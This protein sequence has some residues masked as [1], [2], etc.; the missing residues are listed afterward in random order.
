MR[1]FFKAGSKAATVFAIAS[2]FAVSALGQTALRKALDF[3]NDGKADY[4]IFRPSN[5]VW[6]IKTLAADTA[7][8]FGLANVDYPSPGD[9]DGDGKGDLSVWRDTTGIWYRLNSSNGTFVAN[10]FGLTGDEPVARDY[11][12]DGK[13]D[14]GIVRRSNG[15][16]IWYVLRSLDGGFSAT[17]F[18][19]STDY[20]APGDYD[21]DAKFDIGVQRPGATAASN[22]T[23]Y[24]QRSSDQGYT[25]SSWG[26]SNDLVVPGDYDGDGKTDLAVI[27]EGASPTANLAWYILRSSDGQAII[28]N[29]GLTG[30]DLSVQNDYD[31]DGKA[32]IAI[33]RDNPGVFYVLTS[34]SNFSASTQTGWGL[35][36]DYPVAAYDTH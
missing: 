28:R 32:D 25:I 14:L 6:Y 9:F 29:F 2:L 30:S 8:Q 33:W 4:T 23:F 1:N 3:N 27:R 35:P 15:V 36:S 24:I 5:N 20:T 34:A 16:M 19:L 13:T 18:G 12:G 22:A 21:G 11:D 17:Q 31:G 26:L 10:S 7:Q